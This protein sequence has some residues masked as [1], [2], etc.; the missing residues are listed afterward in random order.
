MNFEFKNGVGKGTY[1][2]YGDWYS[3][4]GG[5]VMSDWENDIYHGWCT[6]TWKD[7]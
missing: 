3:F 4:E 1:D 5:I 2:V 7:G 6:E